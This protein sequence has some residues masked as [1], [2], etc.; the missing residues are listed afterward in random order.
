M[1][2]KDHEARLHYQREYRLRRK[3]QPKEPKRTACLA[4]GELLKAHARKYCNSKCQG[5]IRYREFVDRW[6]HGEVEG[7]TVGSVSGWARRYLLEQGGEQCSRCGW[8]EPHPVTGRVPLEVDLT[9]I[10]PTIDPRTCACCAQTATRSRLHSKP[11]TRAM[12]G[13]MRSC[14]AI[15]RSRADGQSRTG[16]ISLTRRTL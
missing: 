15:L 12:A 2:L 8:R 14:V 10:T 6:L 13:P 5:I 4:C 1:P 16:D 9:A 3:A 11:S 7:R